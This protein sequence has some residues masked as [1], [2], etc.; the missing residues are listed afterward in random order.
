MEYDKC[1]NE[2]KRDFIM[3]KCDIIKSKYVPLGL[4]QF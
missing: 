3:D 2:A 4:G 1:F